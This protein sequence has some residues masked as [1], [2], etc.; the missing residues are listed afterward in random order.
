MQLGSPKSIKD[1]QQLTGKVAS[2][3]RFIARFADRNLPFFKVLRKANNFEWN[4]ECEQALQEL[5][6]YLTTPPL[7][8]NPMVGEKLYVYLAVSDYAVSSVLVREESGK[9][10]PVYYVSKMLQGAEKKYIQIEKLALALVITAR[11]LRPY[12][13]SHPIVVLTNHPLKQVMSKPDTSGPNGAKVEVAVRLNFPATNNEAEYE[14]LIQGLQTALDGG[15]RQVDGYTDSQLVAMQVQG[16]YE[17]RKWSMTQYL[18]R[19]KEM[20]K[21]F[22]RCTISQIPRDENMQADALSRFGSS[23]EGIKE[24]KITVMVKSQPVIEEAEIHLVKAV[25]SWKTPFIRYLKHGELLNDAIAT[26]RPQFKAN[27]FTMIGDDLYKRTPEGILLKCLDAERAQYVL[28]EIHE[29]KDAKEFAKK[30]ESCQKYAGLL[31]FPATPLEPLKVA[32]PFDQWGIDIVGPFPQAVVQKKFLIVAVEYFSKF[33]I[34]RILVS[35]NGTQF[36]GKK[37]VAWC[38]ELKIQQNFT[39]VG[40]P[41]AN[42]QAEV[43]N[44]TLLQ[45]LKT[46][47]EGVKGAWV[48]KLP[49]VLWAYRTTPRTATGE[50]SFCL[51]YGSEAIIPAEID[52]QTD[53]VAQYAAEEYSQQR[54][55]DL[56]VIEEGRDRAYAKILRYKSMMTRN[57]NRRVRPRNFQVG[58]LV[59]K[60]VEVSKHVGKLDPTWEGPYKV[61]K[62]RRKGTYILQDLEGKNLPR[63]WNIHNLKKFYA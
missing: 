60:K 20:M 13:Q 8:S 40:N 62:I 22:D 18:A 41:Q 6:L 16:T 33:G 27:R 38:K 21:K 47:L 29:G 24:R 43:T 58:D 55:F 51:V 25:D 15:I 5:K 23:I 9:Q 26:K 1:V 53:R 30:C 48:E 57:Y 56:T 28:K 61:L 59:L 7:L 31:H 42:G 3:N 50:T 10:N 11:K 39:A 19:V 2:L 46:I 17:T 34:P 32:C 54:A 4:E 37:I 45:Y 63:P 36:Q 49:G 14:A 44:R 12:F 52:E 35:D